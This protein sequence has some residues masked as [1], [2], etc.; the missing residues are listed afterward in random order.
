M[1]HDIEI[2]NL[3]GLKIADTYIPFNYTEFSEIFHI[4][5][6]CGHCGNRGIIKKINEAIIELR[7]LG[8]IEYKDH[9]LDHGDDLDLDEEEKLVHKRSR[10][11]VYLK[12]FS[13]IARTYPY[14]FWSSDQVYKHDKLYDF[15]PRHSIYYNDP[16]F[17]GYR[18]ELPIVKYL[19]PVKLLWKKVKYAGER[20]IWINIK[21]DEELSESPKGY[22]DIDDTKLIQEWLEYR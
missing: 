22:D 17:T 1:G 9:I 20:P 16:N 18:Q 4:S 2:K 13:D 5:N 10:F 8:V 6:I 21:N 11:L 12:E 15:I 14:G 7:R 19:I 3:E